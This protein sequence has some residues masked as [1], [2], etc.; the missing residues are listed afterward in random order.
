MNNK[1]INYFLT[2]AGITLFS[3]CLFEEVDQPAELEIGDTLQQS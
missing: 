1:V 2:L 3:G